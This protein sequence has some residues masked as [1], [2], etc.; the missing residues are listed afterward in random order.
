[1]VNINNSLK[2]M[3]TMF[4]KETIKETKKRA[5]KKRKKLSKE[6][7]DVEGYNHPGRRASPALETGIASPWR[8]ASPGPTGITSFWRQA[9]PAPGE[10]H[11]QPLERAITRP[12]RQAS[13]ALETGI[14]S[15]WRRASPA[16]N[17]LPSSF[18]FPVDAKCEGCILSP[19]FGPNST[20]SES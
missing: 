1:M 9:S 13:P 14:T 11:H 6:H 17:I 3:D 19:A 8:Q 16:Y 18:R 2:K 7:Q 4:T 15:P 10:R 12:W 5:E 20:K